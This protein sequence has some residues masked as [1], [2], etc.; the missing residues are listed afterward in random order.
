MKGREAARA[1]HLPNTTYEFC[2]TFSFEGRESPPS[3]VSSVTTTA[4]ELTVV[5]GGLENTQF[6]YSSTLYQSGKRK[7][8]YRRDKT[9][10]GRWLRVAELASGVT[11]TKISE[12]IPSS[13]FDT[14]PSNFDEMTELKE[15]GPRQYV[16]MWWHPNADLTLE[17]RYLKRPRRMQADWDIPIW[18]PQYHH[19]LVYRALEDICLQHGMNAQSSLYA[20]KSEDMLGR[21]RAKYLARADRIFRRRG[22][23]ET[24]HQAERWGIP[25]KV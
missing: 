2:Y 25:S 5:V 24:I 12:L 16:R 15:H 9:N 21:M 10:N 3:L 7:F 14:T 17:L 6:E 18:P 13:G 23:D 19:T 1:Q 4:T 22:F 8:L 11:G 20:R